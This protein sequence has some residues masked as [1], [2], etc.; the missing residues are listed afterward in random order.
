MANITNFYVNTPL[1]RPEFL[2]IPVN[3]IPDEI[4]LEYQLQNWPRMDMSWL[5]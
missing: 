1:D 5:A 4:M 3:L 2:R